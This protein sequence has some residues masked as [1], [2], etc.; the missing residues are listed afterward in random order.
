ML[1]LGY[2]IVGDWTT[3]TWLHDGEIV[4]QVRVQLFNGLT[5]IMDHEDFMLV[6][7]DAGF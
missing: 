1:R 4:E 5:F 6:V 7:N 3:F 2:L